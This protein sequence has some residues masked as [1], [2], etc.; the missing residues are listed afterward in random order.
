MTQ[1]LKRLVSSLVSLLVRALLPLL[2]MMRRLHA[3]V[4]LSARVRGQVDS[5]VVVT[6]PPEVEG[7]GRIKLGRNL[8]LYKDLYFETR[9]GGSIEIGDD[10][11]ISRGTHL[12][13]HS[14]ITIGP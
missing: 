11:V 13:A 9:D 3:F 4:M 2:D 1:L 8:R 6:G 5:S 12:V 14:T 10:V 7:D